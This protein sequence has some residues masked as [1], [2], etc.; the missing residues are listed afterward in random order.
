MSLT[1]SHDAAMAQRRQAQQRVHVRGAALDVSELPSFAFSHRSLMWWG[2]L[3]L[4]A[5]EGT[6]FAMAVVTYFYLRSHVVVWPMNEPPPALRWGT[7]NTVLLLASLWPNQLAKRAAERLDRNGAR[8]WL[9]VCLL[10]SLLFLV[11]RGLEFHALHCR[12]YDDAYASIVWLL[13]GLHTTHL[14]T[15]TWDTGVLLA[16]AFAG[17]FE[18][19]RFV[20][21]SENALYWIF[22]VASWLPIYAVIYWAPRA[23]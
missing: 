17:P 12:W 20:D 10:A 18:N 16:L 2:T 8:L 11:F 6:V 15:D 4:M 1:G 7:I 3:G 21:V 23:H 19:K 13:L 5:I 14:V 22:V 9:G